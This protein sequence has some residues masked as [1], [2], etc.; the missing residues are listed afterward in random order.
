[1]LPDGGG[2]SG[3]QAA[4]PALP[5]YKLAAAK[6]RLVKSP[7]ETLFYFVQ[8]LRTLQSGRSL[9]GRMMEVSASVSIGAR[10]RMFNF[11]L[12]V[13]AAEQRR[14]VRVVS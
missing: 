4:R 14:L 9:D 7:T 2:A 8:K 6:S 1:M 10:G 12:P 5:L 3:E 11:L 13:A